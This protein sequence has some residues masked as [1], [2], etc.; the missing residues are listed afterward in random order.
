M[1]HPVDYA[2]RLARVVLIS[3]YCTVVV[4]F[5]SLGINIS[6]H[7]SIDRRAQ[8]LVPSWANRSLKI[9]QKRVTY[10]TSEARSSEVRLLR[11]F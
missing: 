11:L 5:Y 8:I 10:C 2:R 7:L 6:E 9:N 1:R 3:T 4:S